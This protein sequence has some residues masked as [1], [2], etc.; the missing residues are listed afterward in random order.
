MKWHTRDK[1]FFPEFLRF[2]HINHHSTI[3]P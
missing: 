1:F 2:Y 3:T